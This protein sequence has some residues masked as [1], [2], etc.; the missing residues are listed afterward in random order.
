MTDTVVISELY[1]S[2]KER[3][4]IK[5]DRY[6]LIDVIVRLREG[7]KHPHSRIILCLYWWHI[8][9]TDRPLYYRLKT[10]TDESSMRQILGGK[11]VS[12]FAQGEKTILLCS[13]M[14]PTEFFEIIDAYFDYTDE[15]CN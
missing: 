12:T 4:R 10:S 9:T 8:F 6:T 5:G 15:R 13:D 11:V 3:S 7:I 14:F 2:L 1:S